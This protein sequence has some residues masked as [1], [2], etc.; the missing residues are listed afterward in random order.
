MSRS[1]ETLKPE[2]HFDQMVGSYGRLATEA[3]FALQESVRAADIKTHT[4][5]SRVKEK[6]SYLEKIIRKGYEDPINQVEDLVGVRVVC[7]FTADLPR[8][9]DLVYEIF[10]VLSE[11]DKVEGGPEESFGYM[12]VH[13]IC[14]LHP[15]NAGPRYSGLQDI[16]FEVQ[17]R[18]ILMDAWA[19]V[20]HYLAYKGEAS[21][22]GPLK[23]DF[24]A[25]AGLFYVADKHFELFFKDA[26]GSQAQA[27]ATVAATSHPNE[28]PVN[29]DTLQALLTSKYPERSPSDLESV[30]DLAQVL[31]SAG[32]TNLEEVETD[33]DLGHVAALAF[34]VDHPPFGTPGRRYAPIGLARQAL[35]IV[36]PTFASV[37]YGIQDPDRFSKYRALVERPK[38]K[39]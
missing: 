9:R 18:T 8:L 5:S 28:V 11:E 34:E 37:S 13:Y 16:K 36:N 2:A 17:C 30:S 3:A 38:R 27:A 31:A 29:R 33:M 21:I 32:Y 10:D 6:A 25:L 39:K 14:R 7:L 22:P 23:R 26:Q 19:N 24:H 15:D 12:S 1:E 35:S 4:I 20:S